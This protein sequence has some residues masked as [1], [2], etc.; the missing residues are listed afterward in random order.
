MSICVHKVAICKHHGRLISNTTK[1]KKGT[2]RQFSNRHFLWKYFSI[3]PVKLGLTE[4]IADKT[5]N[6]TNE[7]TNKSISRHREREHFIFWCWM[8]SC[9][10]WKYALLIYVCWLNC[11]WPRFAWTI[12]YFHWI[13]ISNC[14]SPSLIFAYDPSIYGVPKWNEKKRRIIVIQSD[15]DDIQI[16][17]S[18]N[19]IY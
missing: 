2:T 14:S 6:N 7:R 9:G 16:E 12:L 11:A 5:N 3:P 15:G 10:I 8:I 18:I 17:N 1:K 19:L 4:S 13:N